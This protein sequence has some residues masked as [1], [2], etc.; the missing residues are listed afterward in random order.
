MVALCERVCVLWNYVDQGSESFGHTRRLYVY[1]SMQEWHGIEKLRG[2]DNW[3]L[4]K[5]AVRNLLRGTEG[6]YEASIGELKK[7]DALGNNATNEEKAT[8]ETGL[9]KWDKAD[10]AASQIIIRTLE[11]SV[12]ALLVTCETANEMWVKLHSIYEQQTKQAAHIVQAEFFN[13]CF[14]PTEDMVK[15]IANYEGLILR[16]QN[17]KIKPDDSS[18]IVKFLDTLPEEYEGL[19]QAWWARPEDKQT[20]PNLI[21]LLTS[22]ETRRKQQSIKKEETIALMAARANTHKKN[23]GQKGGNRNANNSSQN[24]NF[25]KENSR[26]ENKSKPFN[27]KCFKCHEQGHLKRDC[28]KNEKQNDRS[29]SNFST[30]DDNEAFVAE[31]LSSERDEDLWIADSGA[32]DHLTKNKH[33]FSTLSYFENPIKIHIGDKSTMDAV[34]RG[35][36]NFEATVDGKWSSYVMKNVLYVPQARRNLFSVTS[37]VDKGLEFK[38]SSTSCEFSR[39]SK[40][41]ARGVRHGRLFRMLIRIKNPKSQVSHKSNLAS[42]D[43]LQVWHE[44]LGHQNKRHVSKFLK[45][46]GID[47]KDDQAFCEACVEGSK[48]EV[49]LFLVLKEVR[50]LEQ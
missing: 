33:W 19:R 20:F 7:P 24:K 9:T 50:N 37:A 25:H 11:S 38:S 13:F 3:G 30:N 21:S 28:P 4:W 5:F 39:D 35:D 27:L 40:V 45:L 48:S 34:G 17:L 32:T 29:E 44:K 43:S 8:Y 12:M 15:H 23:A 46:N 2:A 42:K 26:D 14:D 22:D 36:I 6:A 49:S 18:L 31:I 16:M 47:V 10:R 41:K 1:T